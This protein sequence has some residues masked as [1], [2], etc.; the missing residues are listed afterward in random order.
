MAA[1]T[2]ASI[3]VGVTITLLAVACLTLF[4]LMIVFLSKYQA[5]NGLL[6]EHTQETEVFIRTGER[7]RDDIRRV[8]EMAQRQNQ[9]VVG[10]MHDSWQNAMHR[11]TG[12]RADT[13]DQFVTKLDRVE[14]AG[15]SNLMAVIRTLESDMANLR[16]QL[17]QAENDRRTALADR[18]NEAARV[19]TIQEQHQRTIATLNTD[20]DQYRSEVEGYR[21]QVNEAKQSMD[22]RV[23]ENRDRSAG[24]E[25]A[26]NER[27]RRLESDNLQLV[28]RLSKLQTEKTDS[29]L[30]PT[31]EAALV[32]GGIIGLNPAGGA[33]TIDRGRRDKIILGMTF[34]VYSDAT[35]IRPHPETGEYPG[36]KATIE[37]THVGET[38]STARVISETRGNPIVRGDVIANAIYD[39]S[40]V[41]TFL[42]YG[43]FDANNDGQATPAE[44]ADIRAMIE[45]W[46]G[47]VT[48]ELSGDVDFLILGQRPILPPR[49][50]VG[51]PW[52]VVEEFMRLDSI[53]Q[54]YDRLWEQA[55]STSLPVLNENRLYTL[56]GRTPARQQ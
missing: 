26:L 32:D 54:R 24:T 12:A 30:K 28:D 18:A 42:V 51:S 40:K 3:G 29:L 4:I 21:D 10:F 41:Y 27:I 38:S 43:N 7:Q 52:P 53:A 5:T 47:R 9:S 15:A 55:I 37:V 39:P 33:V 14:G 22:R 44:A 16:T 6:A 17:E 34:A 35:A 50:G 46:G 45:S 1:R 31:S 20:I 13:P 2:S 8:R 36:G 11:V 23:E 49:P 25:T 48:D 19:R 56:I